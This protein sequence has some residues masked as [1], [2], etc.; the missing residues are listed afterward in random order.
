MTR[1]TQRVQPVEQEILTL[2]LLNGKHDI[3]YYKLRLNTVVILEH[4]KIK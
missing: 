4:I 2:H 1:L 3:S